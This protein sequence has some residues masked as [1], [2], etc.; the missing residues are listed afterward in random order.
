MAAGQIMMRVDDNNLKWT[1][2]LEW[3]LSGQIVRIGGKF[4]LQYL[5]R[6]GNGL[7]Y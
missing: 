5:Y 4:E 7:K 1:D 3:H 2:Q 6:S